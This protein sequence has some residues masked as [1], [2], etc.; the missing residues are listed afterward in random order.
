MDNI[1]TFYIFSP[2]SFISSTLSSASL[3]VIF[4]GIHSSIHYLHIHPVSKISSRHQKNG[5][6]YSVPSSLRHFLLNILKAGS[7]GDREAEDTADE[8]STR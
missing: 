1:K 6:V 7:E 4:T 8:W 5:R 2:L 3:S